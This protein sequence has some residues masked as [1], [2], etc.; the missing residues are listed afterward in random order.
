M[1][2]SKNVLRKNLKRGFDAVIYKRG[3]DY[4]NYGMSGALDVSVVSADT[5]SVAG[6]VEGS[7]NYQ[8]SFL[9]SLQTGGFKR[10]SCSC[11][12]WDDCK[13][14]VALALEFIDFYAE[15]YQHGGQDNDVEALAGYINGEQV[16][17][18]FGEEGLSREEYDE[19]IEED[20]D[21]SSKEISKKE[22]EDGEER[23][24]R[25]SLKTLGIDINRL[26]PEMYEALR[27][28]YFQKLNLSALSARAHSAA[29][30]LEYRADDLSLLISS[31]YYGLSVEVIR[32][33]DERI[34]SEIISQHLVGASAEQ[35]KLFNTLG[36]TS[37]WR[38]D[39]DYFE[40]FTQIKDSGLSLFWEKKQGRGLEFFKKE[41]RLKVALA[42]STK[43]IW[44]SGV[45]SNSAILAMKIDNQYRRKKLFKIFTK[46]NCLIRIENGKIAIEKITPRL[47]GILGRIKFK[48]YWS[49]DEVSIFETELKEDE[50][51]SINDIIKD[52]EECL[53]FSSPAKIFQVK[54]F[55]QSDPCLLVDFDATTNHLEISPAV[56]YGFFQ[57]RVFESC[58]RNRQNFQDFYARWDANKYITQF[59]EHFVYYAPVH[60]QKE[61]NLF[62][63]FCENH[64]DLGF[65]RSVEAEFSGETEVFG[66]LRKFWPILQELCRK[67]KYKI[68]FTRDKIDLAEDNFRAELDVDLN[69]END[70]LGFDVSCYLGEEKISLA[71]LRR[72]VQEKQKYLRNSTG[73]IIEVKNSAELERFVLMLESFHAQENQ[74]FSGHIYHAPELDSFLS[75]DSKYYRGKLAKSFTRFIAEAHTG[76][77]VKKISLPEYANKILRKYQKD[78]VDWFYFLRQYRFAGILADDMGLGKT[79]QVLIMLEMNRIKNRPSLVVCPKTLLYNWESEVRKFTPDLRSMIVDGNPNERREKIKTIN[80]Y[81]VVITSYTSLK[82][83]SELYLEKRFNYCILDE[84]QFIKNHATAAAKTVKKINADYRLVMTGTP[85][86][87]SVSEIWSIFDFLMPGF[88]GSFK[89]FDKKFLRP[90][91]KNGDNVALRNL[92]DKTKCFMLRRTKENVLKELPPKIEQMSFCHLGDDQNILYQEVLANVKSEI[93]STVAEKGFA[94]SRIHILAGLTK[95]RQICNH[96]VLLLKNKK[97]T[98]YESTKLEMFNELIREIVGA[99]RKV[100]VFSQFTS[101]LDILADEMKMSNIEYLYLS[102][103]TNKRQE[104]VD[105]FNQNPKQ[106]VFLISLKAGGVGLNLTSADNVIVF[107]PWWNP[108]AENQAV[109]RAHRIGQR[110]SVNVYRLITKGTIEE[111]ILELQ[112]KK[113]YL[114]DNLVGESKDLFKILTWD[115]IK[116]LFN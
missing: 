83:D 1:I 58:R 57:Q 91:M 25:R 110:K 106:K 35:I 18:D 78:G 21:E 80:E 99:G 2:Y 68:I 15:F 65:K 66:F 55:D 92:H 59:G 64:K 45:Q 101:M 111:K 90:I 86:E 104:M 115:D 107:D 82:K 75:E 10:F 62:R 85:L 74:K 50:L 61:I 73:K 27:K 112:K 76:K 4:F 39:H 40:L 52:A 102:G 63:Y 67:K 5:I 28:N 93:F 100:L 14:D 87:N 71:D 109:D 53:D 95:L 36:R 70:W 89:F 72:Y 79:V 114:F 38:L 44:R 17:R 47:A 84:A 31:D 105:E 24:F 60:A 33:E 81:D 48:K 54:K 32:G 16:I 113:K 88:L 98:E 6:I 20:E 96:P 9:F 56:D 22:R 43:K 49:Y 46:D 12:Y 97:Y 19:Y 34:P 11:P 30:R 103:K 41:E 42:F 77:P 23:D 116:S 29:P 13:H 8:V 94:K 69:A 37:R 26:R 108:S 51:I 7:R 3:I